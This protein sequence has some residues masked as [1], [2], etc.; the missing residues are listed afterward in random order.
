MK[1]QKENE[2]ERRRLPEQNDEAEL[3][4]VKG[5]EEVRY[6]GRMRVRVLIAIERI[7]RE[8]DV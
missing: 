5:R 6:L 3:S 7:E 2:E 1:E 4:G 8:L